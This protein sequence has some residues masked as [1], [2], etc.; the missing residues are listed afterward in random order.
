MSRS[1]TP[2]SSRPES[3]EAFAAHLW[4]ATR[5]YAADVHKMVVL[6]IDNAPWHREKPIEEALADNPHLEFKRLPC[7]ATLASPLIRRAGSPS[8]EV[9]GN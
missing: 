3:T 2:S 8:C 9:E 6:I 7:F 4:N 5:F 1:L